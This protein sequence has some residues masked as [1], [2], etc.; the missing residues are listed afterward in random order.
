MGIINT[1]NPGQ[2]WPVSNGNEGVFHNPKIFKTETPPINVI[3]KTPSG[4]EGGSQ[5]IQCI[6]NLAARA[7]YQ[8]MKKD[9]E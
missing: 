2:S 9:N 6:L 3:P 8:N 5:M 4:G 1:T 7:E